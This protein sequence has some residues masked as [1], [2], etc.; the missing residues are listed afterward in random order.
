MKG[1]RTMAQGISIREFARRDGCSDTLVRRAIKDGYLPAFEDGT[2]NPALVGTPWRKGNNAPAN[3][4]ANRSAPIADADDSSLP[5]HFA[6]VRDLAEPVDRG[7]VLAALQLVYRAPAMA[8]MMAMEYGASPATAR[9]MFH[10]L[11]YALM[12]EATEILSA[13]G[14]ELFTNETDPPVWDEDAFWSVNWSK[15]DTARK[16]SR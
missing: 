5:Q 8:S 2:L 10:P 7:A 13:L 16:N 6:F 12:A 4:T 15:L 9:E 1:V 14:C 11:A 3:P